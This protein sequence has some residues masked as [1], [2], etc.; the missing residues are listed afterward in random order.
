MHLRARACSRV[1]HTCA[2]A[3]RDGVA[4]RLY[5]VARERALRS[6]A[7]ADI[8]TGRFTAGALHMQTGAGQVSVGLVHRGH[9]GAVRS[10][11]NANSL[12]RKF[13]LIKISAA[14]TD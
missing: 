3:H 9:L 5:C 11:K 4:R 2:N 13:N 6:R 8:A 12:I 14:S 10:E 1:V 7:R